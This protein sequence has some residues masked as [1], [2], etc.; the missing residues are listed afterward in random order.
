MTKIQKL[1][2][3]IIFTLFSI[4]LLGCSDGKTTISSS[5]PTI[6]ISPTSNFDFGTVTEGNVASPLEVIITNIGSQELNISNISL[7][8]GTVNFQL[9]T[10]NGTTPCTTTNPRLFTGESCT[11]QV[12]FNPTQFNTFPTA[13]TTALTINSNDPN[14][15]NKILN[16]AGTSEQVSSTLNVTINQVE[17]ATC[18]AIAYVSV[19]DQ[20]N[21]PVE[22]LLVTDFTITESAGIGVSAPT[23]FTVGDVAEPISIAI[24]MDNSSSMSDIDIDA[25]N[26]AA[27][28]VIDQLNPTDQ[29]EIIKFDAT[30]LLKQTFTN[31]K[32]LLR[33]AINTQFDGSGTALYDT[34]LVAISDTPATSGRQAIIVITDG[35]NSTQTTAT[36]N[37]II[38]SAQTKGIPIFI[39][40]LGN[41]DPDDITNVMGPIATDTSGQLYEANVA[42]NFR[43]IIEQ[44]LTEVLFTDQYVLNYASGTTAIG[45]NINLT[46]DVSAGGLSGSD[47]TQVPSCP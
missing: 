1:T 26:Q 37:D 29:A 25:M 33:T 3:G 41:I 6:Q 30:I 9:D 42:Q 15:G 19:T 44:Q 34:L 17:T 8:S 35:A 18:N 23:S 39:I 4:N 45:G 27:L 46:I 12:T 21:F 11:V 47:S 22:G 14:A 13:L 7:P 36:V 24:V 5:P 20:S 40:A 31:D 32:D 28:E 10:I 43:T 2:L 38:N 16:L